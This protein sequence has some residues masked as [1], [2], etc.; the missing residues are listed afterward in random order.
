[1]L[2]KGYQIIDV[3][4]TPPRQ[5]FANS[6]PGN[7][8]HTSW[9]LNVDEPIARAFLPPDSGKKLLLRNMRT[10]LPHD[11]ITSGDLGLGYGDVDVHG[12]SVMGAQRLG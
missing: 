4:E 6:K 7:G 11:R 10:K 8:N 12:R 3:Q 9:F 2:G 1:M 5:V